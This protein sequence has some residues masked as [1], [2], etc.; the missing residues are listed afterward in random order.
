MKS[1]FKP[2]RVLGGG[3]VGLTVALGLR[4]SGYRVEMVSREWADL[5][6]RK[7]RLDR[8]SL[9]SLYPAASVAP[10]KVR[11]Q[12][13]SR[14]LA[15]S[16]DCFLRFLGHVHWGVRREWHWEVSEMPEVPWEGLDV[17]Q[18]LEWLPDDGSGLESCPRREAGL[19]VYGWRYSGL[20]LEYP[21][22]LL[23]LGSSLEAL[24]VLRETRALGV[25]ADRDPVGGPVINCLGHDGPKWSEDPVPSKWMRGH[26]IK[27]AA[28]G[29]PFDRR[30]GRP[31][32]YNYLPLP[33]EYPLGDG[34][35]GGVYFYPRL[36]GWVLGGSAEPGPVGSSD[37]WE[38]P[39]TRGKTVEIDG[40]AVPEPIYRLN[41]CL[42]K[43]L[44]GVDIAT[45]KC[46]AYAGYR[47]VRDLEG[48]GA[49]LEADGAAPE[50]VFH[51]YGFGGGGLTLSWAIARE[52][53]AWV[54]GLR[55]PDL[56]ALPNRGLFRDLQVTLEG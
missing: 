40:L 55:E 7:Q 52:A 49:R 17:M 56:T 16:Q 35:G 27:V 23:A 3:I 28:K 4:L 25:G 1:S 12:E 36:D 51:A 34:N 44:T 15:T 29:L 5:E 14:H 11:L 38:G 9:A 45:R 13:M 50:A 41:G 31:Y 47:F 26:L 24:G 46:E 22:Y 32:S 48:V 39:D 43:K 20:F 30:S 37:Q 19:P 18:D 53:L 42:L 21:R 2:I 8:S 33:T 6:M 10:H 54:R